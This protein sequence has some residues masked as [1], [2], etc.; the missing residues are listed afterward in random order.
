MATQHEYDDDQMN[1]SKTALLIYVV[2]ELLRQIRET[3]A[4]HDLSV[5]EYVNR[6]L[7]QSVASKARTDE[8]EIEQKSE[9]LN[10]AAVDR[11]LRTREAIM[12]AHPGQVFEDSVETL[13][14]LREERTRELEQL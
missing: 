3:A 6:V 14:Q 7:E 4:R 2:P 10:R 8:A 9:G 1:Q 5:Q 12:R 13:R 11:L